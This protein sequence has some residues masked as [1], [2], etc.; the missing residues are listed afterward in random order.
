[1]IHDT[2]IHTVYSLSVVPLT[3]AYGHT[4]SQ[5]ADRALVSAG[6][7]AGL[8]GCIQHTVSATGGSVQVRI[9]YS[10]ARWITGRYALEPR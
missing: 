6:Q 10:I 8:L 1:M 9:Q 7:P 2:V 4:Q 5:M 3:A